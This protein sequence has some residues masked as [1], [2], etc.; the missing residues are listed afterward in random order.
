MRARWSLSAALPLLGAVAACSQPTG[1]PAG[2]P[3]EDVRA[4]VTRDVVPLTA[5]SIPAAVLERLAQSRVVVVGETHR[6]REQGELLGAL[7][8]G[9]YAHGFRQLLLEWPQMTDWLLA[10]YVES[11]GLEPSYVPPLAN[12]G[13]SV[14]AAIREFNRT[15]PPSDRVQVHAIDVNLDEYGGAPLFANLLT[16]LAR[17]LPDPAPIDAFLRL[18]YDTPARQTSALE[19]LRSDL[20]RDRT[21]LTDTWGSRWYDVVSELVDAE[22]ASVGIRADRQ[23]RY[24]ATVRTREEVMK[25]LADSLLDGYA[26]GTLVTAGNTHAQKS[27]LMGTEGVEWLGD[28][29][30]HRSPA[31]GGP[32]FVVCVT[33]ARVESEG[34]APTVDYDVTDRSPGNE[35]WRVMHEAWPDRIAF[36]PLDDAAFGTSSVLMNF[37]GAIYAGAPR[38][39][40]DAL[41]LLPLGHRVPL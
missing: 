25:R 6:I 2:L 29:L 23:S 34:T 31:A 9:L 20:E 37:D 12:V 13:G 40:Y 14:L 18:P 7:V 11:T 32:V 36:L 21:T 22:L 38:A 17:H 28:Y 26:Y 19:R 39:H 15:L 4:A 33:P 5:E 24:D 10:D 3:A 27:P 1:L 8:R 41:V 16:A 35:I 30:V